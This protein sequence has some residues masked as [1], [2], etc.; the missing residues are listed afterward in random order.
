MA[1]ISHSDTVFA[2]A[3]I[4]G[5]EFCNLRGT[6]FA[7]MSDIIN[8]V[9]RHPQARPGMITVTVRNSSQGWSRTQSF[10]LS[11]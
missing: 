8:R 11:A 9:R 7:G 6:G 3:S 10:Y 2:S 5:T 4:C 1:T